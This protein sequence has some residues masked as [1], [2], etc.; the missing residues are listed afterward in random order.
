MEVK[1]H[2][3]LILA[4]DRDEWPDSCFGRFTPEANAA[5]TT[6]RIGAWM[7]SGT[8]LDTA[9]KKINYA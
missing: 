5:I 6:H 1:L 2:A 4:L 9:K 7:G 3:F 8:G